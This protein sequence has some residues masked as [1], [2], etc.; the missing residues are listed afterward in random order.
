MKTNQSGFAGIALPTANVSDN[1][2]SLEYQQPDREVR[3]NPT[4]KYIVVK[5]KFGFEV[6]ILF[7]EILQHNH[8]GGSMPIVSAGFYRVAGGIV[9]TY[10]TSVSLGIS[11]R[12]ADLPLVT[13]MVGGAA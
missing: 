6:A 12:D 10:G 11:S 9:R 5:Q 13:A 8:V 2:T 4:G 3:E 1:T 7:P